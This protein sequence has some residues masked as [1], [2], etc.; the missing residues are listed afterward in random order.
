[1]PGERVPCR[2][3]F[4]TVTT[5]APADPDHPGGAARST[6]KRGTVSTDPGVDL[7]ARLD[8][9][10]SGLR[11]RRP[12]A[13]RGYRV[14]SLVIVLGL[15]VVALFLASYAV[16]ELA[17]DD[18]AALSPE[19]DYSAV[20]WA[21]AATFAWA[22]VAWGLVASR[23]TADRAVW[24]SMAALTAVLA[25]EAVAQLH[26]Q[27]EE[28]LGGR[29]TLAFVWP[30]VAIAVALVLILAVR[31]LRGRGRTLLALAVL[32][33]LAAQYVASLNGVLTVPD[34]VFEALSVAEEALE[35]MTGVL[36][37]ATAY[38]ALGTVARRRPRPDD[39]VRV[40][41]LRQASEQ[42]PGQPPPRPQTPRSTAEPRP[43]PGPAPPAE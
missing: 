34:A 28:A 33:L 22:A 32:T 31:R 16:N 24:W 20:F 15:V 39:L 4:T 13:L 38:E 37:V 2:R 30:A 18:T 40:R 19:E 9:A 43:D 8:D 6:S 1:M 12:H 7:L 5:R 11:L 10:D 26:V 42:R 17:L 36:F 25:V 23:A 41:P 3:A 14:S 35:L 21:T 27:V 29:K